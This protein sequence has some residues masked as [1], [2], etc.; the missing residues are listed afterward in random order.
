M[1]PHAARLLGRDIC[2][3]DA[4]VAG[5]GCT[6]VPVICTPPDQCHL[7]GCDAGTGE[8]ATAPK[9]DGDACDDANACTQGDTCQ[10]GVY[11]RHARA[12][13]GR[14]GERRRRSQRHRDA[15]L[16]YAAGASTWDVLRG[17]LSALPVGPGGDD[18]SLSLGRWHPNPSP[19][20]PSNNRLR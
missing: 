18:A 12:A 4:C 11:Q 6:N 3:T 13:A 1:P 9:L 2:T 15:L 8:C 7:A 14:G 10:S 20:T 19:P 16:S 17:S 5:T